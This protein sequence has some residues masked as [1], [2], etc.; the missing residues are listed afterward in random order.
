MAHTVPKTIHQSQ[1]KWKN[2]YRILATTLMLIAT[3]T[4]AA[5]FNVTNTNDSGAGSLRAAVNDANNSLGADTVVFSSLANQT[6]VLTSGEIVITDDLTISGPIAGDA[7]SIVIDGNNSSRIFN[8]VGNFTLENLTLRRGTA[9]NGN[10]GAVNQIGPRSLELKDTIVTNNAALGN[11][12]SGGGLY[13][14][15]EIR[16]ER[17]T[18]SDNTAENQGGGLRANSVFIFQSTISGNTAGV[19]G[20][21]ISSPFSGSSFILQSTITRNSASVAG[22]ALFLIGRAVNIRPQPVV[23]IDNTIIAGNS[24]SEGNILHDNRVSFR[25]ANSIFGDSKNE[26]NIVNAFNVFTD[27][28]DLGPLQLNGGSTPTHLPNPGSP[29]IDAGNN[30]LVLDTVD[31]RGAGFSRIVNG[32][33]DIGAVERQR[34]SP[35]PVFSLS[36][37]FVLIMSL[38]TL[39]RINFQSCNR[40]NL[41]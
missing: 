28:P 39:A 11:L 22:G 14:S 40:G 18:V 34:P 6:I 5:I 35:I 24:G 26:I 3:S 2:L 16:L 30:R 23:R 4:D 33:V 8:S 25:V 13:S 36:G 21:G 15:R 19:S 1:F 31:Q 20:G 9:I 38:L 17:S 10:G 41:E 27:N 37:L 7:K 32:I 12:A 29:A